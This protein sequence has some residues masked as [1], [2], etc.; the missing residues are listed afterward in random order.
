MVTASAPHKVILFGEHAVVH[1]MLGIAGALDERITAVV[2]PSKDIRCHDSLLDLNNFNADVKEMKLF[3]DR[4]RKLLS[5]KNFDEIKKLS[6]MK[7]VIAETLDRCDWENVS[8]EIK[9]KEILKGIG[10]S[11]AVWAA[12][13]AAIGKFLGNDFTKEQISEISYIGDV[14]AHG[15]TPSGIDNSTVTFG[16]FITY[17]KETGPRPLSIN[18]ELPIIVIYSDEFAS[19]GTT[20]RYIHEQLEKEPERVSIILDN[21]NEISKKGL[22]ALN[23]RDLKII[24][25]MMTEYYNE[26][27]K[28]GISTETLDKIMKIAMENGALGAKPTG[29][30][31]GG[32]CI[33]LAKDA[34]DSDKLIEMFRK[35]GFRA[36]K[37]KL[38][39]PGV[40][41]ES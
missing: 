13:A 12:T 8:V 23:N 22:D 39:A 40:R 36:F 1:G 7:T 9:R 24:G 5:E 15:G 19:T 21:L 28:L 4:F 26:L 20:V 6:A 2:Q 3:L 16:G 29:G 34:V 32:V 11:S 33:A 27:H 31:G 25:Q 37:T 41:I 35:S 38:G 30:W 17:T 14:V 10:A 18:F